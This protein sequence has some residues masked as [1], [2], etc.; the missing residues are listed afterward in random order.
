[1]NKKERI[2]KIRLKIKNGIRLNDADIKTAESENIVL[3]GSVNYIEY[4]Q[5]QPDYSFMPSVVDSFD[6]RAYQAKIRR[7]NL[8][9]KLD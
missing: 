2:A 7:F 4:Q 3:W 9:G 1:M 6:H 5:S 8:T